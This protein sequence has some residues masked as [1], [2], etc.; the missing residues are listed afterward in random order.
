MATEGTPR[1]PDDVPSR[2]SSPE[3]RAEQLQLFLHA[4]GAVTSSGDVAELLVAQLR[5]GLDASGALVARLDHRTAQLHLVASAGVGES[6]LAAFPLPVTADNPV[7]AAV[8]HE[9]PRWASSHRELAT[10]YPDD[11]IGVARGCAAAAPLSHHGRATGVAAVWFDGDHDWRADERSFLLAAVDATALVWGRG[12]STR[13]LRDVELRRSRLLLWV[14]EKLSRAADTRDVETFVESELVSR[15]GAEAA[16]LLLPDSGDTPG[17]DWRAEVRAAAPLFAEARDQLLAAVPALERTETP[18]A[19]AALAAV[20]LGGSVAEDAPALA[21]AYPPGRVFD[22]DDRSFHLSLAALISQALTRVLVTERRSAVRLAVA[23]AAVPDSVV[24][25]RAVRHADGSVGHF[26]VEYVNRDQLDGVPASGLAVVGQPV[27][28]APPL[29]ADGLVDRYFEVLTTGVTLRCHTTLPDGLV[30]AMQATK[31]GPDDLI[32]SWRDITERERMAAALHESREDLELAQQLADMGSWRLD[33]RTGRLDWSSGLFRVVGLPPGAAV[34]AVEEMVRSFF[35]RDPD[36]FEH[37]A[38][39]LG[40]GD[41]A[42]VETS[43]LR[44]DGD[45]RRVLI[46][47]RMEEDDHGPLLVRGTVQDVT[48]IRRA[49]E[50]LATAAAEL[51]HEQSVIQTLQDSILPRELPTVSG[52]AI[53]ARYLPTAHGAGV[54]GDWYDVIALGDDRIALVVGDV[55]GHGAE[56]AADMVVLRS[57]L[58]LFLLDRDDPGAALTRLNRLLDGTNHATCV[59]V[60]LDPSDGTIVVACAGHPPPLQLLADGG[61]RWIRPALGPPL[62]AI[63]GSRYESSAFR[64]GP[65]EGIVLYTDGLVERRGEP[66]DRGLERLHRHAVARSS[67]EP[68]V[69]VDELLDRQLTGQRRFDDVCVLGVQRT[70]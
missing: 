3:A 70:A 5:F 38:H 36:L 43:L 26:V 60:V 4:L 23:M 34:P 46:V 2:E 20:P 12:E 48:D 49:E 21:V 11:D 17:A 47:A 37:F 63:A 54:G 44:A 52:L 14:A 67:T 19:A 39:R 25:L 24:L 29:V 62:G 33:L 64:L 69:V 68:H 57:T 42:A 18:L 55:A 30:F 61:A 59:V 53:D 32:V 1:R 15:L 22:A 45:I 8:R 16:E 66:I 58:R 41:T 6:V 9:E 56:S 27:D 50:A 28:A 51:R 13:A 31:V 40:S 65:G 35:G 10:R 7:A